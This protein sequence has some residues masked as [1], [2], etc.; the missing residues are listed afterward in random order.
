MQRS[1]VIPRHSRQVRFIPEKQTSIGG[2]CTSAPAKRR[3]YRF[4]SLKFQ[5][6]GLPLDTA[7]TRHLQTTRD[8]MIAKRSEVQT[9]LAFDVGGAS[10]P[11]RLRQPV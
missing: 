9:D 7:G 3:H 8:A 5:A 2:F 1:P 10:L 6:I 11:N 4:D